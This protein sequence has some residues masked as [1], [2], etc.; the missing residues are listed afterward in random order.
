MTSPIAAMR[1]AATRY[2]RA[3]CPVCD[4]TS[5]RA[6]VD[7]GEPGMCAE[8]L[9]LNEACGLAFDHGR[10]LEEAADLW[11]A[12]HAETC[13]IC[14]RGSVAPRLHTAGRMRP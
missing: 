8:C 3:W 2:V 7:T 10:L 9:D 13:S 6:H 5:Y 4:R 12:Y 14:A 11:D 1:A